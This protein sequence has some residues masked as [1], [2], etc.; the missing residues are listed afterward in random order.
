MHL[1]DELLPG[2]RAANY[3]LLQR[4]G[5]RLRLKRRSRLIRPVQLQLLSKPLRMAQQYMLAHSQVLIMK[6]QSL[7]SSHPQVKL[8]F[9]FAGQV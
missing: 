9:V 7:A 1:N 6:E 8:L 3:A 4:L 5:A 2:E